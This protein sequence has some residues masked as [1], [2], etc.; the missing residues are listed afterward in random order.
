MKIT[1][2]NIDGAKTISIIYGNKEQKPKN[3]V[4]IP[5]QKEFSSK[6]TSAAVM[7]YATPIIKQQ[8][9]SKYAK[10]SDE[11][12]LAKNHEIGDIIRNTTVYDEAWE[13][14]LKESTEIENELHHRGYKHISG[15]DYCLEK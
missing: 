10:L 8:E 9:K 6:D 13:D 12:L 7:A 11:E 1:K 15:D 5:Q 14:V 2:S 4:S 3:A